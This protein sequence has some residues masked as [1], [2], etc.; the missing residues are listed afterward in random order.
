MLPTKFESPVKETEKIVDSELKSPIKV[1]QTPTIKG[2]DS[3]P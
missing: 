1:E 2:F 3:P